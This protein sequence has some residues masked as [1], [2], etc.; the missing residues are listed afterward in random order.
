MDATLR[1]YRR[2]REAGHDNVGTVLQAYLYR[3]EDDLQAL[4]PLRPNVRIV[5]GAYL[6][7]P[8]VAYPDKTEVD[9]AYARLVETA[10]RAGASQGAP[11]E[12]TRK[13]EPLRM[14]YTGNSSP[15]AE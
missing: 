9:A 6:E 3:S 2:L 14:K 13:Y 8:A 1:I 12:P 4:L 15:L 10:L 11:M 7:P 5:K